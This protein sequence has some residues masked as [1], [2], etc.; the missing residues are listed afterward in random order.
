M[1]LDGQIVDAD[2]SDVVGVSLWFGVD[3]SMG[4]DFDRY[5]NIGLTLK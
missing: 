2:G 4:W 3:K 1:T 5:V